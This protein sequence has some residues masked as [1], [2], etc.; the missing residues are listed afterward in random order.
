M[1]TEEAIA[2][3]KQIAAQA[4]LDYENRVKALAAIQLVESSLAIATA[5]AAAK[6]EIQKK[7]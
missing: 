2:I 5:T 4:P 3:L 7:K 1:S 6:T